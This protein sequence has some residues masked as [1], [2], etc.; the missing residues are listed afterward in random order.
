M[1]KLRLDLETLRVE[2]FAV[3]GAE[4]GGRGTVV[5]HQVTRTCPP[6]LQICV[7]HDVVCLTNNLSCRISC[8]VCV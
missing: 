6:T 5:G 2:S 8:R 1:R 7:T 3:D 4:D